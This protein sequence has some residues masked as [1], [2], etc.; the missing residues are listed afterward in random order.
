M[1]FGFILPLRA[2]QALFAI[3]VLGL[4]AYVADWF[5]DLSYGY[6]DISPSQVNFLI[7]TS[8]WTLLATLYLALS[9]VYF[10]AFAH[11]FAILAVDAL[12]MLFWFAGFIA[13]S[14]W[15]GDLDL[16]WGSICNDL[17]AAAVFAAFEWLLFAA[18][19]VLAAMHVFSTRGTSS[20]K[21]APN[22]EVHT[23]V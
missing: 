8:A 14:V 6:N 18:T 11:K 12:T 17:K 16:C 7:F 10:S 22:M 19:T 5:N 13:L 1:A 15:I 9:P 2:A 4:T 23:G 21:P 3:I 20:T